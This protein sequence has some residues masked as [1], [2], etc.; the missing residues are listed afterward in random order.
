MSHLEYYNN[1]ANITDI[2]YDSHCALIEKVCIELNQKDRIEELCDKFLDKSVKLK[3]KKDPN[4]PKKAKTSYMFF[5]NEKRKDV[6]DKYPELKMGDIS[7]KLGELWKEIS[8]EDKEKYRELSDHDRNRYE[9]ELEQYHNNLH[10]GELSAY[11][12]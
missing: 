12:E 7:K 11:A 4:K 1:L 8:E 5:T 2:F 10:M 9:E 3:A 6:Q